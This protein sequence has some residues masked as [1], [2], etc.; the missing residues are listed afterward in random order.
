MLMHLMRFAEGDLFMFLRF[1]SADV[2]RNEHLMLVW[3]L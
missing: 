3:K 1:G 2:S